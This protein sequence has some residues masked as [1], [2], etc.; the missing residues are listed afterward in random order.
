MKDVGEEEAESVMKNEDTD[1]AE[2]A[3]VVVKLSS[4]SVGS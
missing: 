4:R 2:V 3:K 1:E